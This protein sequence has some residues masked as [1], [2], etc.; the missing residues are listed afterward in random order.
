[1]CDCEF[2]PYDDEPDE[3]S[4]HFKRVCVACGQSWYGLHCPHDGYQNP[5]PHC[6][7]R[8]EPIAEPG[9]PVLAIDSL[10]AF[11]RILAREARE[12]PQ[13]LVIR[14]RETATADERPTITLPAGALEPILARGNRAQRRAEAARRRR[15]SG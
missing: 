5:C 15:R 13:V 7:T 2:A 1:M 9:V 11:S 8:P 6:G 10:S 4:W 3:P 12:A 14:T